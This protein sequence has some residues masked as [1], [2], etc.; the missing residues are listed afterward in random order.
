[1]IRRPA[2]RSA[3]PVSVISTTASAISGILASV[4]PCDSA[5]L[6]LDAVGGQEPAGQTGVLGRDPHP[7]G[8]SP[9]DRT[10]ESSLTAR[11]SW[12][13]REVALL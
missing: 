4:A 13:G 5:H 7:G 10:G 8:S 2:A 9:T 6:G 11:T 1:M 12:I 3:L